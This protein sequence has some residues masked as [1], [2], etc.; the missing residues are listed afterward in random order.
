MIFES[1]IANRIRDAVMANAATV[2]QAETM[3]GEIV[4]T[5]LADDVSLELVVHDDD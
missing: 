3:M 1:L 5:G 2:S 4:W